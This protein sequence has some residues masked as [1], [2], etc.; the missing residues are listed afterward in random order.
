M[1]RPSEKRYRSTLTD[2]VRISA[3]FML[4]LVMTAGSG[5]VVVGDRDTL[6]PIEPE[7]VEFQLPFKA[8]GFSLPLDLALDTTE[9]SFN[10]EPEYT[11]SK[12]VRG[13]IPLGPDK[14]ST[15]GF[16]WDVEAQQLY[17]DRNV[18]LDLTDDRAESSSWASDDKTNQS[19]MAVDIRT[20]FGE[21]ALLHYLDFTFTYRSANRV[22]GTLKVTSGWS[23]EIEV[24][25]RKWRMSVVNN[26]D[27]TID[28]RDLLA[29]NRPTPKVESMQGRFSGRR[30]R[31]PMLD[32]EQEKGF[33]TFPADGSLE[34]NGRFYDLA[35]EVEP[36]RGG[37]TMVAAF[38][39][40]APVMGELVLKGR[41]ISRLVLSGPRTVV[42]NEPGQRVWV[43]AGD[44]TRQQIVIDGGR[45]GTLQAETSHTVSVREGQPAELNVGGPLD[46][47][48]TVKRAGSLVTLDYRLQGV[49][50]EVYS[51]VPSDSRSLSH[52]SFQVRK[53]DK[54][55]KSYQFRYG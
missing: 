27:G 12:V 13:A 33:P 31:R 24:N 25:G 42:L 1:T 30:G 18:N 40:T 8:E 17:I 26:L 5:A 47:S 49:G 16:A 46:N 43:P 9:V 14:A 15:M 10:K 39:E 19:F 44:Y 54:T 23:G 22:T 41:G 35:F 3:L 55:I 50:G 6:S 45:A 48:M 11:S 38:E 7:R 34:I 52:A 20:P 53:R 28:K 36:G 21:R 4:L 51:D 29:L 2:R 32:S 37:P